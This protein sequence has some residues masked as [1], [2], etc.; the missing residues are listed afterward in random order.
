VPIFQVTSN[1][2]KALTETNF[3][4]EGLMQRKDIQRLLRDQIDVLG[5]RLMVIAEEFGDWLDSSRRIDL[6]CIDSNANLVVVELKRT[7]D[8]GHMEL[9]SLRYAAMVSTMTFEQLVGTLARHRSKV[10]PD[11]DGA[12]SAIKEFLG[13]EEI[14]E[15]DI[16]RDVRIILAAADFGKELTTAVLWLLDRE[17]DIR[18]IRLKPYRMSD[19]TVLLDVQQ[20]IPL[21][22]TADFQTQIGI[23]KQAERQNRAERHD[24][25][26]K[27]W[28]GLLEL[29]KTKSDAHANR[30]PTQ[31]NWLS[32]SIGRS[33]F[34]LIYT[35]RGADSQ[36]A[37]WIGLGSGQAAKNKAAFKALEAQKHLIETDFGESLEW[38]ELPES[39]GCRVRVVL[40]GGYKS[41]I[42]EWP[43]VQ[44]KLVNAMVRLETAMRSRVA[45]LEF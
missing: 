7:D 42:D 27:F 1:E 24:L 35:V 25:R 20:L 18:C 23:K 19:G 10:Q 39:D 5:E 13:W 17:I 6:L 8:G 37:L 40:T 22:E 21:P 16:G 43:T 2:L 11:L 28:E 14:V 33:G 29:A 31:D 4:A 32:G 41:P 30:S 15:E 34:L 38:Q 45:N 3:S 44:A 12:R 36:V 26:L 9:Q